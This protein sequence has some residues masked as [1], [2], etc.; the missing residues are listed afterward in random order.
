VY[1]VEKLQ[2]SVILKRSTVAEVDGLLAAS[3]PALNGVTVRTFKA[4]RNL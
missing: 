3:L 4:A 2:L 1:L